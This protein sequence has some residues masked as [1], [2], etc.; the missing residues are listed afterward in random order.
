MNITVSTGQLQFQVYKTSAIA[1]AEDM[2]GFYGRLLTDKSE[3]FF[4]KF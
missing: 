3:Y 2:S 4:R 1:D